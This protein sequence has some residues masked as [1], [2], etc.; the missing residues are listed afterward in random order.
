[1]RDARV[2][3]DTDGFLVGLALIDDAGPRIQIALG[4]PD[5]GAAVKDARVLQAKNGFILITMGAKRV[6]GHEKNPY[7]PW[8]IHGET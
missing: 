4:P 1:M 3:L 5:R 6:R 8:S 2:L 7:V